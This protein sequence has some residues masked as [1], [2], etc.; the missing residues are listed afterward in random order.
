MRAAISFYKV[1]PIPNC[2][3]THFSLG[4]RLYGVDWRQVFRD[5]LDPAD[6]VTI[7][8]LQVLSGNPVF[9]MEPASHLMD[10][11][12]SKKRGPHCKSRHIATLA[13]SGIQSRA[14]W[15]AYS[16]NRTG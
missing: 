13:V 14:I 11:I 3:L 15:A 6:H 5:H 7:E 16:S 9:L 8:V 1:V 2:E 4:W 12:A 10:L